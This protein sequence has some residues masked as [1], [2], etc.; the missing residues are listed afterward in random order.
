MKIKTIILMAATNAILVVAFIYAGLWLASKMDRAYAVQE[1]I[2]TQA[3][4]NMQ[5][6]K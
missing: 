5:G 2:Y 6:G 1:N 4:A 3:R